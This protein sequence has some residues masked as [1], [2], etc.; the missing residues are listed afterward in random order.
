MC[1]FIWFSLCCSA[2]VWW[3][4]GRYLYSLQRL[5]RGRIVMPRG[6]C[7]IAPYCRIMSRIV[8]HVMSFRMPRHAVDRSLSAKGRTLHIAPGLRCKI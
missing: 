1:M 5:Q 4:A 2:V 6:Y 8:S 3:S 7:R